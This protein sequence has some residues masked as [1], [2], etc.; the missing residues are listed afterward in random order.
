MRAQWLWGDSMVLGQ[1][2]RQAGLWEGLSRS[3]KWRWYF[4][5]LYPCLLQYDCSS[6]QQQ[7]SVFLSLKFALIAILVCQTNAAKGTC[8]SRKLRTQELDVLCPAPWPPV[9]GEGMAR[10][11]A[12]AG[13]R[14]EGK[15]T[16]A[17]AR[18]QPPD[19]AV[20]QPTHQRP[21]SYPGQP[22]HQ[23]TT[24]T[25]VTPGRISQVWPQAA[26]PPICERP[27]LFIA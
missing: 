1:Q 25:P 10:C 20:S 17:T 26:G 12:R 5:L 24:A 3:Q 21:T 7:E 19:T 2:R 14:D 15:P 13:V 16:F 18:S 23:Q 9:L 6:S 22:T 4:C 8:A 11:K 27:S